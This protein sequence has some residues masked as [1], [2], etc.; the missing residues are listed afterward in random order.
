M[1]Y[2]PSC[3]TT[4]GLKT[5][6]DCQPSPPGD[7]IGCCETRCHAPKGSFQLAANSSAAL[8]GSAKAADP[9]GC[10]MFIRR[11]CIHHAAGTED[12]VSKALPW[13]ATKEPLAALKEITATK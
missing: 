13:A 2:F 11:H 12:A 9:I 10:F 7:R 5:P 3:M 6:A 4:A 8:R 1:T